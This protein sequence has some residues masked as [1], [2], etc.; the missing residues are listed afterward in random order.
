[1][2]ILP[3]DEIIVKDTEIGRLGLCICS[4]IWAPELPRVLMLKG[5]QII[6]APGRGTRT[7]DRCRPTENWQIIAR[8][9]AAEN[10]VYLVMNQTMHEGAP[11]RG[12]TA[13]FGPEFPLGTL[14]SEGILI[15]DF[16]LDRIDEI[17][18]R[19][20]DEEVLLPPRTDADLIHNRPGQVY[21]RRPELY[22]I[23][24]EPTEQAFNYK[25]YENGLDSYKE[26][27]ERVKRFNYWKG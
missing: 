11:S 21:D 7:A 16:D 4:E 19:Y 23:L 14:T 15:A 27:Y 12:R 13:I 3:G 22:G 2:H 5:A 1:M 6:L 26:E 8:A 24:A 20:I 18:N 10:A 17:R 9:R 25:Y